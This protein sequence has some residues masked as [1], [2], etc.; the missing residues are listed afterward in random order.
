MRLRPDDTSEPPRV[1]AALE[2]LLG[3]VEAALLDE[4]VRENPGIYP[5]PELRQRLF[6]DKP[7]TPQFER[8]RTRAWTKV[9]TGT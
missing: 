1:E 4:E 9:K 7:V 5:P 3:F 2:Q 8:L 6:F